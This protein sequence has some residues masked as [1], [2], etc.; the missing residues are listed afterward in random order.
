MVVGAGQRPLLVVL[1][2]YRSLRL[3]HFPRILLWHT[4]SKRMSV[5]TMLET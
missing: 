2:R 4:G 5:R 3:L 1:G